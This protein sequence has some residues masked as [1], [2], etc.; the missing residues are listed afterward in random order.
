MYARRFKEEFLFMESVTLFDPQ[1]AESN[2]LILLEILELIHKNTHYRDTHYWDLYEVCESYLTARIDSSKPG[3]VYWGVKSFARVW[4]LLCVDWFIRYRSRDLLYIDAAT[5]QKSP[6]DDVSAGIGLWNKR[7]ETEYPFKVTIDGTDTVKTLK[8]DVVIQNQNQSITSYNA[9]DIIFGEMIDTQV[10]PSKMGISSYTLTL[11]ERFRSSHGILREINSYFKKK[12]AKPKLAG[13][14]LSVITNERLYN[15]M[16]KYIY[17]RI[18]E[19]NRRSCEIFDIKY[20]PLD[21]TDIYANSNSH[22]HDAIGKQITYHLLANQSNL[23]DSVEST[24]I[25]PASPS[26]LPEDKRSEE[27]IGIYLNDDV[28]SNRFAK[29]GIRLFA[30]VTER[31]IDNFCL[32]KLG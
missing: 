8:P 5:R 6:G 3:S 10:V 21:E 1:S 22:E 18:K 28:R 4:E 16:L 11:N 20:W 9:P 2:R 32:S 25:L 29:H 7:T 17:A 26:I 15:G 23:F 31:V 12:H 13:Y 27:H 30:A 19:Q 24:F 14:K